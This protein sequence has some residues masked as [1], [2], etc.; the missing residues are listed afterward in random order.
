[1]S[2]SF[3]EF[4]SLAHEN[5]PDHNSTKNQVDAITFDVRVSELV[6]HR[7]QTICH[8]GFRPDWA[9]YFT[10]LGLC[11]ILHNYNLVAEP[12]PSSRN[13]VCCSLV[14][15]PNHLGW[16]TATNND[17]ELTLFETLFEL[18]FGKVSLVLS[19]ILLVNTKMKHLKSS[20]VFNFFLRL[21][22]FLYF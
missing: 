22:L 19:P 9:G 1:M 18:R 16:P 20:V 21:S 12:T 17:L 6:W 11:K 4:T 10:S 5:F 14:L 15:L 8:T 13:P 3:S 2:T 7:N